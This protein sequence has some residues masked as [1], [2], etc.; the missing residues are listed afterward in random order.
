MGC[1]EPGQ[2]RRSTL[3]PRVKACAPLPS[4]QSP[5]HGLAGS[6]TGEG[7][8]PAGQAPWALPKAW[9]PPEYGQGVGRVWVGRE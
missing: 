2:A 1:S 6:C 9:P 5:G 8:C 3:P 7:P 4:P